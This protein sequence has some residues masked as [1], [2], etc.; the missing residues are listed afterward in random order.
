MSGKH[1]GTYGVGSLMVELRIVIPAVAGSS[2]VLHPINL[3]RLVCQPS[4]PAH[5]TPA[6]VNWARDYR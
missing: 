3:A 2:P 4:E 1:T 5:D 6:N